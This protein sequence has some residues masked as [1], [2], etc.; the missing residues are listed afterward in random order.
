MDKQTPK[1][2]QAEI[3]QAIKEMVFDGI[4]V[5]K[6]VLKLEVRLD[7]EKVAVIAEEA[8]RPSI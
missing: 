8:T 7:K 6:V 3:N 5:E 4:P 1:S 2:W